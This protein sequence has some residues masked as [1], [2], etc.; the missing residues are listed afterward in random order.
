MADILPAF[1]LSLVAF[2]GEELNLHI[3]E[4]RYKQLMH[5]CEK[6]GITFTVVPYY[7]GKEL[8]YAAEMK[9]LEISKMYP[10]G[11]MDVK[12]KGVGLCKI[13]EFFDRHPNK[14]YPG[15][16]ME[17]LPWDDGADIVL[18]LDIL[19]QIAILYETM[20]VDNVKIQSP[21]DFRTYQIAHKVGFNVDQE[22]HF[23]T[24]Q[25]E[26]DR[27]IYMIEHLQKIIPVIEEM[28]VLKQRAAMNGHFKNVIP[29]K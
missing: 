17:R 21:G 20:N 1:P 5:E 18:T 28:E 16:E 14:L 4:P 8:E 12:T 9:L 26:R 22:L 6:S 23:L 29:R 3:F 7:D 27:Q 25:K 11:K 24:L 10:D 13:I 15:I 2:P 19:E